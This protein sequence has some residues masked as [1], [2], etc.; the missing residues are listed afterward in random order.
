MTAYKENLTQEERILQRLREAGSRG[1]YAY[2]LTT[3]RP[4]GGEGICQYNSRIWGLRQ[5][6]YEIVN[7][8][9]GHF[10][11]IEPGQMQML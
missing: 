9:P 3:P 1:V 7:K 5:K 11:L 10:V 8:T 6:G 4:M 2:E